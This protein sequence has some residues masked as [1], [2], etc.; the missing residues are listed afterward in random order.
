MP[1]N[2]IA[3]TASA[4]G[5]TYYTGCFRIPPEQFSDSAN[6]YGSAETNNEFLDEI[7]A[8]LWTSLG[9]GEVPGSVMDERDVSVSVA[10][11]A[12]YIP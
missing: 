8:E 7:G 6:I 10:S 11:P 5:L 9:D 4:A 3:Y 12:D 2:V 1:L